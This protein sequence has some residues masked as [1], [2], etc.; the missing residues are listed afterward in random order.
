MKAHL[1][2]IVLLSCAALSAQISPTQLA[3]PSGV[4]SV[5][6][7]DNLRLNLVNVAKTGSLGASCSVKASLVDAA[8]SS[9]T[10]STAPTPS[11]GIICQGADCPPAPLPSSTFTL[12][13]GQSASFDYAPALAPG[14]RQALLA[15][16]VPSNLLSCAR[17]AATVE[18]S[19]S[20]TG[21][22]AV[23][24]SPT[25]I[26]NG[27]G[28][29]SITTGDTVRLNVTYPLNPLL[30]PSPIR[31][32]QLSF[33]PVA[34]TGAAMA[35]KTVFSFARPDG[36]TGILQRNT[37][38]ERAADGP[39]CADVFRIVLLRRLHQFC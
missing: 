19:D 5:T 6:G 36:S 3:F 26:L 13:P 8:G 10:V 15:S 1:S 21:R 30:P 29:L 14:V 7:N 31:T 24:L 28:A 2:A 37:G 35:Q 34:T 12:G 39:A 33:L 27:F 20:A 32:L 22:T 16:V 9:S 25:P 17:L 18:L 23:L 38:G 4:I 11:D